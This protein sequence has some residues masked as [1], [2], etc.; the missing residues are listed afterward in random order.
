MIFTGAT[1]AGD[2]AIP[3]EDWTAVTPDLVVMLDGATVRTETGCI[4]GAAWY[5]RKLGRRC[6]HCRRGEP[7]HPFDRGTGQRDQ[8]SGFIASGLRSF[9]P[10]HPFGGY[11]DRTS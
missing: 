9:A 5:A 6:G 2:P 1:V 3:N 7:I 11:C 10:R 4:H 8:G